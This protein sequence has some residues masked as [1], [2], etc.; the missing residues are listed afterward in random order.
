MNFV[1]QRWMLVGI[2]LL[3]LG[4]LWGGMTW[5]QSQ[6]LGQLLKG[7]SLDISQ[8]KRQDVLTHIRLKSLF[9]APALGFNNLVGDWA[10]LQFLQYFGD[11]SRAQT[12]YRLAPDYFRVV[13]DR[14][15]RFLESYY[16]LTIGIT[17]YAGL[18]RE[19]VALAAK[20]L[21]SMTPTIPEKSYYVWRNKGIDELL[22]LD[23]ES[24]SIQSY[25]KA[26]EWADFYRDPQAQYDASFYRNSIEH[27]KKHPLSNQAQASAWA[28]VMSQTQDDKTRALVVKQIQRQG[29]WVTVL[30]NGSVAVTFPPKQEK[31][32]NSADHH[33]PPPR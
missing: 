32:T 23:D 25:T 9:H 11:D 13:V 29:G 17:L 20:G 33:T 26:A 2:Q 1:L 6:R 22:Y 18:P 14:N 21:Q 19:S 24:A 16:Y 31:S 30:P 27:L 3:W 5:L 12:G 15:P 8:L 4:S 28:M 10:F 7:Q